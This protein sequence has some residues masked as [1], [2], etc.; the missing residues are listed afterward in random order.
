MGRANYI[1]LICLFSGILLQCTLESMDE[2]S[3]QPINIAMDANEID[4]IAPIQE[5]IIKETICLLEEYLISE[6]L[7]NIKCLD[8]SILVDLKYSTTDNFMKK[9][10]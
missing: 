8:S 4:S 3:V 6:G 2:N 10:M 1:L 7:V 5:T 9:N